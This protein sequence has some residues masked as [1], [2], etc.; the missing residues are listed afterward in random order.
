MAISSL[1][2]HFMAY[3]SQEIVILTSKNSALKTNLII[4][5]THTHLYSEEFQQDRNEMIQRALSAGVSR[6]FIPS[7]NSTCTS[8]KNELEKK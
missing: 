5:D 6:F 4:T 8:A 2:K 3:K 7:I 1:C